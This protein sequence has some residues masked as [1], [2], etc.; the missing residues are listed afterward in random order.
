MSRH[1]LFV[2][3]VSGEGIRLSATCAGDGGRRVILL[4]GF[5]E[6]SSTW[7]HQFG[8]LADAGFAVIAPD[9]R[10]YGTSDRPVPTAS[11]GIQHLVE[12]VAAIIRNEGQ[13][14]AVVGH[15]W[16][17]L[18]AWRLAALYPELLDKL[19]I[20]N[21]P[22]PRI[23]AKRVRRPPQMFRSWYLLPA[24]VPGLSERTLAAGDFWIVRRMFRTMPA[25]PGTFPEDRIER[26]VDGLRPPGALTAAL[27]Y[28]RAN[29][30]KRELV[31]DRKPI[32][33]PTLVVWGDLDPALGV[34]LLDGL[35]RYVDHLTIRRI[36]DAGHWVQNEAPEEVNAA[37]LD[38]L[39]SQPS[40]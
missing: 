12:D 10:G 8:P 11:Y 13:R 24:L 27:S 25:R 38:F 31:G 26:F 35:D 14:A 30:G 2:T 9:L 15:D 7:L 37:L 33:V 5:P 1:P 4:H 6:N 23:F 36:P 22:H 29:V 32:T 39:H 16:G 21:S 20:L 34:D 3:S 17:G 40:D 28:Y 18:I 19:V